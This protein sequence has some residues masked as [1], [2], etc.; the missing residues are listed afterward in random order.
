MKHLSKKL[1]VL[2]LVALIGMINI[3]PV[4]ATEEN[5]W[6][7][8]E[9]IDVTTLNTVVNS[10]HW[11]LDNDGTVKL[12]TLNGEYDGGGDQYLLF[13]YKL[14]KGTYFEFSFSYNAQMFG[15]ALLFGA[16]STP[17]AE[18]ANR[19]P[20]AYF[21]VHRDWAS[22]TALVRKISWL[23]NWEGSS[24]FSEETTTF[25]SPGD[26]VQVNVSVVVTDTNLVTVYKDGV[27]IDSM[28]LEQYNGGYVGLHSYWFPIGKEIVFS[29]MTL[30]IYTDEPLSEDEPEAPDTSDVVVAA[31][32]LAV[33]S[34]IVVGVVSKRKRH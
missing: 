1:I 13:D 15:G 30:K 23:D 20:S 11:I 21:M 16:T 32:V 3:I 29:N 6:R 5:T 22:D 31:S 10:G 26:G 27:E 12:S 25:D 28:T 17:M 33:A 7:V 8:K 4:S 24:Y 2:L 19:Y 14:E 34:A 18:N 9:T